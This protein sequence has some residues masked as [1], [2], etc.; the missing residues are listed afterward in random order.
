MMRAGEHIILICTPDAEQRFL[1]KYRARL[2][3]ARR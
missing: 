1:E 3:P 2:Y